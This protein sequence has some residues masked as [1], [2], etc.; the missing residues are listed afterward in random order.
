M[1]QVSLNPKSLHFPLY[2]PEVGCWGNWRLMCG[3]AHSSDLSSLTQ[4]RAFSSL[5]SHTS[6][7]LH[8][9]QQHMGQGQGQGRQENSRRAPGKVRRC[10]EFPEF[11]PHPKPLSPCSHFWALCGTSGVTLMPLCEE[12]GTSLSHLLPSHL[13]LV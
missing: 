11:P 8:L 3:R 5:R 4:F 9:S 13:A 2:S 7:K 10:S 1:S 12:L 6:R